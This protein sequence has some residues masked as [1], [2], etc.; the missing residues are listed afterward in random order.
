MLRNHTKLLTTF[1]YEDFLK[2]FRFTIEDNKIVV[3]TTNRQRKTYHDIDKPFAI[4]AK[5]IRRLS[6]TMDAINI[7]KSM[8]KDGEPNLVAVQH[9]VNKLSVT[10]Q[11][12]TEANVCKLIANSDIKIK[13]I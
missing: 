7:W 6:F 3:T 4:N 9:A 12:I 1:Q 13:R 2:K 5:K 8:Y 11:P 10:Y